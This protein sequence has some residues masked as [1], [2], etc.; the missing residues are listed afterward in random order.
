MKYFINLFPEK[1]QDLV[2]KTIYFAFHYLRYILVITQFVVICVFFYRFKVDQDIVDLRDGLNQKKEI[3]NTTSSLLE[4]VAYLEEKTNAL[5]ELLV[6]QSVFEQ[7]VQYFFSTV[8]DEVVVSNIQISDNRV[9]S[10]GF[11]R[12]PDAIV[13]YELR[14]EQEGYFETV[15]LA[16][17]SRTVDG[18]SFKLVLT[19]YQPIEQRE[20]QTV[21]GQDSG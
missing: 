11:S 20:Q 5:S 15:E 8:P 7:M 4:E 6:E 10:D 18:F 17:I 14:L 21:T 16:N 19:N 13:Q 2:D 9:S 3:V 12:N 1:E